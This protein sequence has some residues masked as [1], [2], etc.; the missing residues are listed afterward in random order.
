MA[1][2]GGNSVFRGSGGPREE[3]ARKGGERGSAERRRLKELV[4]EQLRRDMER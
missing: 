4:A 1:R 2:C 3:S